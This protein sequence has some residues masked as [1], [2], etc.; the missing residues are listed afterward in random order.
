MP[1]DA[2]AAVAPRMQLRCLAAP[3][4]G[5]GGPAMA[6]V[7]ASFCGRTLALEPLPPRLCCRR[8][9]H[10]MPLKHVSVLDPALLYV[11]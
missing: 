8:T 5:S 7:L 1:V 3:G 4:S 10:P 6:G 11:L 2:L 9:P